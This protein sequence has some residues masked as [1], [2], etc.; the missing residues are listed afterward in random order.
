LVSRSALE[1]LAAHAVSEISVF[2]A[3]FS[4][5]LG[6]PTQLLRTRLSGSPEVIDGALEAA[7]RD[8]RIVIR[9]GV[10][11]LAGWSPKPTPHQAGL[12]ETLVSR[13]E[14][15][16]AEPPGVEELSAGFEADPEP[17][18]R[19]LERQGDVV[20]VEQNRYYSANQLKAV[21]A[22]IRHSMTGGIELNPSQLREVLGLSR[23]Y[24]IPL[25]E[26]CDRLG[27]TNRTVTGRVWRD[28]AKPL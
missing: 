20:Q 1:S 18:L 23:K 22:R 21:L 14:A 11:M 16:G 27:Y 19:Y 25:L 17:L 24:L 26:Y 12:I 9:G 28:G 2:H 8:G 10:A 13:L 15:A 3:Q 4:L 7:S 5:D 6:M